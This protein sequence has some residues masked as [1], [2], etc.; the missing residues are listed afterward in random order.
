[1]AVLLLHDPI[2]A[3]TG[4]ALLGHAVLAAGVFWL[5]M[6]LGSR[7][8]TFRHLAWVG[9]TSAFVAVCLLA[10]TGIFYSLIDQGEPNVR[11]QFLASFVLVPLIWAAL[12]EFAAQPEARLPLCRLLLFYVMTELAIMLLQLA[13]LLFGTGL[14]PNDTYESMIP[15][16]QFNG[17]NLAAI[18]VLLS[19]FYNASS[20]DALL[21]ERVLFNV[22]VIAILAVIFSRLAVLLYILDRIRSLSFRRVKQAIAVTAVLVALGVA[23]GNMESTGNDA[24]DASLNKARSLATVADAGFETDRSTSSR[25]EGYLNY[26]NQVTRLGLGSAAIFDYSAYTADAVFDD[27]AAYSAPPHSMVIEFSYWMGWAGLLALGIFMLVA[28]ARSSQGS[29]WQRGFLLLAAFVAS[30][31]PSSAIPLPPLWAGLLLLAML[32]DFRLTGREKPA[33]LANA[34]S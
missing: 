19:I 26:F 28:Y 25:K 29:L 7:M 30:T 24:I 17:N 31:I 18:V 21:M 14:A 9:G 1:M 6:V 8:L 11:I 2:I 12:S 23:V 27:Q 3:L 13:Y 32:G 20:K 10:G 16:S 4:S 5:C 34:A 15:G 33:R 22:A